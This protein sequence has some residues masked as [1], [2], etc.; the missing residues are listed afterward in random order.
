MSHP[1][2]L[3]F[4]LG[5]AVRVTTVPCAKLWL[6]LFPQ[7]MPDGLLVTVP[8]PS[9]VFTT[10]RVTRF[11]EVGL[12][13]AVT[14]RAV[15]I[16]TEQEPVPL[17]SPLHPVKVEPIAGAGDKATVLPDGKLALQVPGQD[18]PPGLLSTRPAPAPSTVTLSVTEG[19]EAAAV[20]VAVTV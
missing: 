13:V 9:P 16:R 12:N 4:P 1:V 10:V 6:Q 19:G 5:L 8:V 7:L 3:E 18:I 2:N 11:T 14:D 20:K 15:S 17:Q